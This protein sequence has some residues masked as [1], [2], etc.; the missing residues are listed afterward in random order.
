MRRLVYLVVALLV[1]AIPA[2]A[3]GSSEAMDSG[4]MISPRDAGSDDVL[5][6]EGLPAVPDREVTLEMITSY[7]SDG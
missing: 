5:L 1:M 3:T 6:R 2:F 4:E 7:S